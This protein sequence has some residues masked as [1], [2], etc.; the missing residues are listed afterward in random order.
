LPPS[1]SVWN[2]RLCALG[3]V[4]RKAP[5]RF[6]SSVTTSRRQQLVHTWVCPETT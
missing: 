4:V 2:L 5:P 3:T 6:Q 1:V